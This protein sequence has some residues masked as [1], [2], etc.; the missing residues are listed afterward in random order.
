MDILNLEQ[1]KKENW[2]LQVLNDFVVSRSEG[3]VL[4]LTVER[5]RQYIDLTG[6]F[7]PIDHHNLE[8]K[9]TYRFVRN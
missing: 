1:V 2:S 5:A 9:D 6:E 4:G 7:G 3:F 8:I